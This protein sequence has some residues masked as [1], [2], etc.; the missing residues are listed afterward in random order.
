MSFKLP[1]GFMG[2]VPLVEELFTGLGFRS[3]S[4]S[5]TGRTW[6]PPAA[7]C[8]SALALPYLSEEAVSMFYNQW[9]PLQSWSQTPRCRGP[10]F[11]SVPGKVRKQIRPEPSP[12]NIFLPISF[13]AL[14]WHVWRLTQALLFVHIK[15]FPQE[16]EIC[17]H[18]KLLQKMKLQQFLVQSENFNCMFAENFSSAV[19]SVSQHTLNPKIQRNF[20]LKF[21]PL[22][23]IWV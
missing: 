19:G 11:I 5:H 10:H 16:R 9:K 4:R 20:C 7:K 1:K 8:P 6:E 23:A 22:A 13:S 15:V 2:Q 18:Q 21:I 17:G 12:S 3:C 14:S